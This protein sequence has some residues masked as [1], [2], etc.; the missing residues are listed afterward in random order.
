MATERERPRV[1]SCGRSGNAGRA[2]ACRARDAGRSQRPWF[3]R[4]RARPAGAPGT[5]RLPA[6]YT[7]ERDL[8]LFDVV[9]AALR[10]GQRV[11]GGQDRVGQDTSWWQ[12]GRYREVGAGAAVRPAAC[13]G[14]ASFL[15]GLCRPV[16]NTP[17]ALGPAVR[18][19]RADPGAAGRA[20]VSGAAVMTP[21]LPRRV[22][23]AS[24]VAT[25]SWSTARTGAD[26][27]T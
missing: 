10:P 8:W 11:G 20:V 12:R 24:A 25:W 21:R 4:R 27:A 16:L 13:A 17:R 19:G 5:Q 26:G 22:G 23:A 9:I 15:I 2:P 7:V 6:G 14:D 18:R 1:V 3:A